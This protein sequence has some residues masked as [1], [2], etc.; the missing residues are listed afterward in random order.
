[1]EY[2]NLLQE[3]DYI[4]WLS[5]TGFKI[6]IIIAV[7]F[8]AQA[9]IS[10]VLYR[11][12]ESAALK[13]VAKQR[14]TAG[15]Q[16]RISTLHEVLSKTVAVVIFVS[17]LLILFTEFG[18]NITPILAGAG[19]VGL[20]VG[21]GAQD[22]IKNLLH[23]IFI[24]AED[25]YSEGDIISVAG[26]GGV[27]ED[28]DLRRTVLRDLDG[29]QHHIPNGEII[30]ASNKSKGWARLNINIGVNYNTDLK[31]LREVINK[32]G[33]TM[34][35]DREDILEAPEMAG[36]EKFSD[37]S[38]DVKILGKV[39]PGQQWEVARD[40]R[41]RLKETFEKE[42]IDIPFPHQVIIQSKER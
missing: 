24:L 16:K 29:T 17:I 9:F 5:T 20:A 41:E 39:E 2:L 8:I 13:G 7:G 38:I 6:L 10:R 37:S 33:V 18:I 11:L 14:S 40:F 15:R 1:M 23:G 21:F 32:I 4:G 27:V 12:L 31:K 22:L 25:Q 36:V 28:F 26:V 34:N 35:E 3:F 19:V 42:G 30:V